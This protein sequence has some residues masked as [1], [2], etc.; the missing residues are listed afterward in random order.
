MLFKKNINKPTQYLT[1]ARDGLYYSNLYRQNHQDE[2]KFASGATEILIGFGIVG[3]YYYSITKAEAKNEIEYE[4]TSC[5]RSKI[6]EHDPFTV[7]AEIDEKCM[8]AGYCRTTRQSIK[9][10]S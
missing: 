7:R 5:L 4:L 8:F 1:N 3:N 2:D 9:N 10:H 6:L